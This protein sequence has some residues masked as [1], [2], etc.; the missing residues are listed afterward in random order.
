MGGAWLTC[1]P[2]LSALKISE[3]RGGRATDDRYSLWTVFLI[4]GIDTRGQ[5]PQ[6]LTKKEKKGDFFL[7]ETR[8]SNPRIKPVWAARTPS[9]LATQAQLG[10]QTH[11]TL[12]NTIS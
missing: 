4:C 7:G 10:S 5:L 2:K 3:G 8:W 1:R 9:V 11:A 12:Y 6:I